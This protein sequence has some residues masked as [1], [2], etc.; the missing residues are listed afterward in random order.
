Y[1]A[2]LFVERNRRD[3][4][5]TLLKAQAG[6]DVERLRTVAALLDELDLDTA[7][8]ELYRAYAA[9]SPKPEAALVLADFLGQHDR[10]NE[11]LDPCERAWQSCPPE[12]VARA[13]VGVL[14]KV[15]ADGQQCQRVE[16]RL[17]AALQA[18]PES[19]TL[20]ASLATLRT[21]QGYYREAEAIYRKI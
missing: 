6:T 12:D 16:H 21:V 2:R 19:L 1:K 9:R 17:E 14:Y 20:L 8:E 5:A 10:A 13:S 3:E 4:A 7:A 11:E 18:Q 15:A